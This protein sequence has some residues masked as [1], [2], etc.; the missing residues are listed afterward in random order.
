M[1]D[2]WY[3]DYCPVWEETQVTARK[4]HCCDG[5]GETIAAAMR[6]RRTAV[7]TERG[8]SWLTW[9]HCRRCAAMV[10]A[11]KRHNPDAFGTETL[12]LNCGEV[13]DDP[14]PE[15]AALAFAMPGDAEVCH[16]TT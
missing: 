10:D 1:C 13:W 8:G 4:A 5:C 3:D 15:V 14:P 7:L 9:K 2:V 11:L 16:G 12:D 6:Y